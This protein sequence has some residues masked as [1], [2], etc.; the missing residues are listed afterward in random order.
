MMP[1]LEEMLRAACVLEA[2]AR[3]AGNVHPEA[4]F[5]D[6]AYQDFIISADAAAPILARTGEL[7]VGHAIFEAVAAT[8]NITRSNTNLGIILLLA[9]LAAVPR[10]TRLADGIGDVLKG[11]TL[12]DAQWAYQA[13]R[14][15]QPGG[16]GQVDNEDISRPPTTTLREAM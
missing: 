5:A 10:H 7:G 8:K 13:I 9:P 15:A 12:E 2:T 14:L 11:L 1:T 4:S 16:M 6:L 3:K